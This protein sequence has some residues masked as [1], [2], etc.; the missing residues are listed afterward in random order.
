VQTTENKQRRPI[1]IA[2]FSALCAVAKAFV[3]ED[4]LE[5]AQRQRQKTNA[6]QEIGG[7]RNYGAAHAGGTLLIACAAPDW[8]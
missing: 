5:Y 3:N 6:N 8:L 4:R 7:P 1:L 2:G